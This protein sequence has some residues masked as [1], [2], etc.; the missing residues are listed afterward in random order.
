[1]KSI[2]LDNS[3]EFGYINLANLYLHLGQ[4]KKAEENYRKVLERNENSEFANL[5][6]GNLLMDLGKF[7]EAKKLFLKT[8]EINP[9]SSFA[10]TVSIPFSCSEYARSLFNKPI[11]LPSCGK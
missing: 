2:E 3:F 7:E 1:M 9:K 6:L 10:S 11:S 5:N 8:I 4:T